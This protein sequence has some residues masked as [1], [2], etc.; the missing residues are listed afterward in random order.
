MSARSRGHRATR[1]RK[2]RALGGSDAGRTSGMRPDEKTR[3]AE[4]RV[5]PP[6]S[7]PT[8]RAF[9]SGAAERRRAALHLRVRGRSGRGVPLVLLHGFTGAAEAWGAVV[10]H[11]RWPGPVAAVDLPGHHPASLVL[12]GEDFVAAVDRLAAALRREGLAPAAVAGYSMGGRLALGLA[13]R[14][15]HLPRLLVAIGAHP[16]L[17]RAEARERRRRDAAMAKRI[18]AGPIE[19][20]VEEWEALP[21]FASQRRR[22][23]EA[24]ARQRAW[25]LR[26]RP[27]ALARALA[28]LG[29]GRQPDLRRALAR[30]PGRLVA[31]AGSEDRRY[32]EL[33]REI[34]GLAP[35]GRFVVVP[36]SGHNLLLEAPAAVAREIERERR[37]EET[38]R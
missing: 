7:V 16:G 21:L 22:P 6:P 8:P 35:R 31:L 5:G 38:N 26:H 34:A 20:F 14:H 9:P 27:R 17:S 28:A 32:A 36:G 33:A 10:A 13:A 3:A 2:L 25:R 24:L 37:A 19:R 18:A 30:F 23:P 11:L 15:P 1:G 4:T 12:P 29:P